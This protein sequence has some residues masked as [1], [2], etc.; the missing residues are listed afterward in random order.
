MTI[1]QLKEMLARH[2]AANVRFVLPD[3]KKVRAHA[4]VTE[5]ARLDKRFV[6]CG[7]ILR[8]GARCQ[9][10]TWVANDL[11]HRLTAGKLLGI[12]NKA[13]S[14]LGPDD[15]EVDVEHEV[16]WISQFPLTAVA[17]ENGQ[18]SLQLGVRHTACLAEDKCLPGPSVRSIDFKPLPSFPEQGKCCGK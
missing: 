18:V 1:Q 5:V 7:G 6:D 3:G 15:L 10:Q 13:D 2:L 8:N 12:L 9:L 14:L 17:E 11:D 16:E 4:H